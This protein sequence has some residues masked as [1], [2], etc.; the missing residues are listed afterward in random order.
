M[1]DNRGVMVLCFDAVHVRT[2]VR[3]CIA[4]GEIRGVAMLSFFG[5]V[6]EAGAYIKKYECILKSIL[7]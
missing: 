4:W 2:L 5:N 3:W 1:S 7:R 6:S